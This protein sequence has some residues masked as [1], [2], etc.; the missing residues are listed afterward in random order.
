MSALGQKRTCAAQKVMSALPPKPDIDEREK[1]VRDIEQAALNR[2]PRCCLLTMT[3]IARRLAAGNE[4][5]L[6]ASYA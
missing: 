5:P 2:P 3:K 6:A 1:Y 4:S